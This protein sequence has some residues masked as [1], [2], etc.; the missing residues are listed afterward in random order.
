MKKWY[1]LVCVLAAAG[2]AHLLLPLPAVGSG[3]PGDGAL[4]YSAGSIATSG[5][6]YVPV[7]GGASGSSIE[8]A[9]QTMVPGVTQISDFTAVGGTAPGSGNSWAFTWRDNA[10]SQAVACTISGTA[11]SCS[12]TTDSFTAAANDLIDIQVTP[13]VTP[14]STGVQLYAQLAGGIP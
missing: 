7:G 9:V 8:T 1:F 12:D 14:A 6:T 3:A 10:T 4:V 11:T 13:G 5:T 2:A